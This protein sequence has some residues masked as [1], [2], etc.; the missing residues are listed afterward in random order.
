MAATINNLTDLSSDNDDFFDPD[1]LSFI[2]YYIP[3][4]KNNITR[5]ITPEPYELIVY[6]G[7]LNGL[8][9]KYG[10]TKQY[11]YVMAKINNIDNSNDFNDSITQLDICDLGMI[12]NLYNIFKTIQI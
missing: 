4:F 3:I 8:L 9:D 1:F 5:V 2:D 11:H 6:T 10:I 12:D 7:D